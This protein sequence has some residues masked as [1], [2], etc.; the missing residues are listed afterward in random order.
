MPFDLEFEKPLANL[1]KEIQNLRKRPD[2]QQQLAALERDLAQRLADT[3]AHLTPWQTVL[4]ARHKQRPYTADYL[5]LMCDDV[6]ELRG[7]RRF[8]DDHAIMGGLA[9]IDGRPVMIVGHQKGRDLKEK[10]LCN[11]GSPHPEG[12][13]KAARLMKT[14]ERFGFP[15]VTLVDTAGAYLDLEAEERGIAESIAENVQLMATLR[16]PIVTVVIGEGGSGGALGIAV[17]DRILMLAHS[18]YTVA[19]PEAAASILWR[20]AAY[21]HQA[22]EAMKITAPELLDLGLID[23]I[24]PEPLGGAHRDHRASAELVKAAVLEELA[25]LTAVPTAVLLDRRY[26]KWRAV[27]MPARAGAR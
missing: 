25:A 15:I 22:A 21:A 12:Y 26:A 14:A 13:R 11:F 16:S 17:A 19:A 2:R 9:S 1:D 3:Y 5:K 6:F 8:G 18:I 7:D 24:I 23:R 10:Q 20:D 27:G 4:V